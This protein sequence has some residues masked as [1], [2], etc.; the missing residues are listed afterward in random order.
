M[1]AAIADAT[2]DIHGIKID[3]GANKKSN[4]SVEQ[5]TQYCC[6]LGLKEAIGV[7]DR[8]GVIG[9]GG[10]KKSVGTAEIQIP[11]KD[12]GVVID[13]RLLLQTGR[14]PT[15]LCLK[16]PYKNIVNI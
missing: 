11:F 2:A 16:D 5:Y 13:I 10:I 9:I 4:L 3:T 15:L 8:R 1:H 7:S 14:V 6:M 12:L